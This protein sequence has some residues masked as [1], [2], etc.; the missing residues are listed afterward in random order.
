G[1]LL[2]GSRLDTDW[3]LGSMVPGR[4]GEYKPA[5]TRFAPGRTGTAFTDDLDELTENMHS[6]HQVRFDHHWGLWYDRRRI[7]HERVRR[8]DGNVWPPFFEQPWARSGQG[9]AWDGL[10]KYDLTA[11]NPWYF[12]RLKEFADLCDRKGLV[13]FQQMYFQ[14][15]ILEAGA[16][17]ADFPWRPANCLQEVGFPE[18]PPYAGD[19]RIFMAEA[20]YDVTHPVRRQLHR[21]YIRHCLDTLGDNTNVV[22]CTGEEYTGPLAFVEFWM[23]TV[24]GWQKETGRRVLI[25]LSCT[26][27]VQD[28]ILA[29]PV[30]G[31]E[32]AVI[33]MKFWWP[34]ADG[35]L[36][37]PPGGTNLSPRQQLREWQGGKSR[38]DAQTARLVRDYRRRYPDKAVVCSFNPVN[39]WAVVAAGASLPDLPA[40]TPTELLEALPRMRPIEGQA[41]KQWGLAEPGRQYLMYV[42]SGSKVVLDLSD[43]EGTYSVSWIE[44]STGK[45]ISDPDKVQGGKM[46]ELPVRG[47]KPCLVW[48]TREE[49]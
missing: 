8:P 28:A 40:G 39:G 14:H 37:D 44:P 46:V 22:Y 42:A 34:T 2:T 10:S 36:Y 48:L 18:P 25:G 17:W 21:A 24:T 23:D 9:T 16:H 1:Q 27:D 35:K 43:A 33:D 15:N 4:A 6:R 5:V 11:F 13:L 20:F 26:K 41:D 7:D 30:R 45:R 47:S 31:P 38:S 32:V 12:G 3:W 29:D 49:K 19:K